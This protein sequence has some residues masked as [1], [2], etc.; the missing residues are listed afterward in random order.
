MVF[1][2]VLL[3]GMLEYDSP[4]HSTRFLIYMLELRDFLFVVI[5]KPNISVYWYTSGLL[6]GRVNFFCTVLVRLFTTQPTVTS[7][8]TNFDL[9]VQFFE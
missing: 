5:R 1:N 6:V 2:F 7:R 9:S 8:S 4:L 3:L